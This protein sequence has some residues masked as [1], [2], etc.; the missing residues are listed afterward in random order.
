MGDIEKRQTAEKE[1]E[2]R[3]AAKDAELAAAERVK[4]AEVWYLTMTNPTRR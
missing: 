3:K 1:R 2:E 4:N